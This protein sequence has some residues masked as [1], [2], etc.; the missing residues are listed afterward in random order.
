LW[1]PQ[2]VPQNNLLSFLHQQHFQ[3]CHSWPCVWDYIRWQ[4]LE[5]TV[6]QFVTLFY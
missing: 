5:H 4:L 3:S 1:S 6:C 2:V